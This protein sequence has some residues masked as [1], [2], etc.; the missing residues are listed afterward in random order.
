MQ[1]CG[2]GAGLEMI[3]EVGGVGASVVEVEPAVRRALGVEEEEVNSSS[4]LN[5]GQGVP[6]MMSLVV[7]RQ[8]AVATS[9]LAIR[10]V[11]QMMV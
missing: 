4:T 2:G 11:T 6:A 3:E 8:A 7:R 9:G 10:K 5:A 1:I